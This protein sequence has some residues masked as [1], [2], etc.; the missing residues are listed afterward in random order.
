MAEETEKV[1]VDKISDDM[2][3]EI[4]KRSAHNL[5]DNPSAS[6]MKPN[7]IKKMFWA[8]IIS[9]F[10]SI[11]TEV[12][13]IVKEI[14]SV[15][16]GIYSTLAGDV[17][18]SLGPKNNILT[19]TLYNDQ[20][21]VLKKV[22]LDIKVYTDRID[23]SAVTTDKLALYAVTEPKIADSAVTGSKIAASAVT[24]DKIAD[25]GITADKI[26]DKAI[27]SNK[28]EDSAVNASHIADGAVRT[29]KIADGGVTMAKLGTGSVTS[30]KL[31][32]ALINRLLT[33]ESGAFAEIS[34]DDSRG[35][36]TFTYIDGSTQTV[37]FPLEQYLADGDYD[38]TEGNEAIVLVLNNGKE[39]RIPISDFVTKI[40]AYIDGVR[41]KMFDLQE[42]PP[43]SS[44]SDSLLL[45]TPTLAQ[46]AGLS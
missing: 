9:E 34:Y 39:I 11:Y 33:L 13:R 16:E 31:S 6:G 29:E 5:P 22:D 30:D 20:G 7:E 28:I 4:K 17:E 38:D 46:L 41:E 18:M 44:L 23:N 45:T 27:K 25:G 15:I 40:F 2:L 1:W 32:S 19:L 10:G 26:A 3:A 35:V 8:A 42:A 24:T 43:I 37:N 21:E 14:N 12:N 36:L